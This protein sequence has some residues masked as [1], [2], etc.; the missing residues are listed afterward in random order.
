MYNISL[1]FNVQPEIPDEVVVINTT[2]FIPSYVDPLPNSFVEH[3][4]PSSNIIDVEIDFVSLRPDSQFTVIFSLPVLV[5]ENSTN[6]TVILAASDIN[7]AYTLFE[8]V[9]RFTE[10]FRDVY[11]THLN[12]TFSLISTSL[13]VTDGN[14]ITFE[15]IATWHV[16]IGDVVGPAQNL[17]VNILSR[18]EILNIT[19]V[20]VLSI[21]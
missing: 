15:E 7:Y 18:N 3:I 12:M 2:A 11:L 5:T 10:D 21:G 14:I 6:R 9:F 19:G 4:T 16:V 17:T 13:D 20:S 1:V 8:R